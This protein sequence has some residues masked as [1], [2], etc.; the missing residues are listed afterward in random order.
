M[1][2]KILLFPIQ[3]ERK[4]EQTSLWPEIKGD[5]K[6]LR[7]APVVLREYTRMAAIPHHCDNCHN[8]ILP[9]DMYTGTV[10]ADGI[11]LWVHKEHADCPFDPWEEDWDEEDQWDEGFD[12]EESS[13]A[14]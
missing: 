2:N 3:G 14:A 6:S 4:F 5:K 7:R 12:R 11:Y 8:D 13:L 10:W 1:S 9:G